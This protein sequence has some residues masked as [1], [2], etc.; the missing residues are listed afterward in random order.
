MSIFACGRIPAGGREAAPVNHL[1]EI[2]KVVQV[3]HPKT[4]IVH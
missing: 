2:E 3:E 4:L 1:H